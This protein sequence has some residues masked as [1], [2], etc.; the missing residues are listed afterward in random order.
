[1]FVILNHHYDYLPDATF[2]ELHFEIIKKIIMVVDVMWA[3]TLCDKLHV[4]SSS[5]G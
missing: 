5:L 1:M 4:C 3:S 2:N